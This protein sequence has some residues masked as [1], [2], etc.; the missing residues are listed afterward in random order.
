MK[1]APS[2]HRPSRF[3]VSEH[4]KHAVLEHKSLKI[5]GK[6]ETGQGSKYTVSLIPIIT[7]VWPS[8]AL[9]KR[10]F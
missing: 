7:A 6:L 9:H 8:S 2:L 1:S 4:I 5:S 3:E 10:P